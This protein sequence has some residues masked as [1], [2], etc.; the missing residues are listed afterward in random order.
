MM[1]PLKGTFNFMGINY[2]T[3]PDSPDLQKSNIINN[4]P[5]NIEFTGKLVL[6]FNYSFVCMT[7]DPSEALQQRHA[8]SLQSL[9]SP[10]ILYLFTYPVILFLI[11]IS[12]DSPRRRIKQ[13]KYE[14]RGISRI[15][16]HSLPI[17]PLTK[18]TVKENTASQRNHLLTQY[19]FSS[20][21]TIE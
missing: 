19:I 20:F 9:L 18:N 8:A 5:R 12:I 1:S 2:T 17:K 11:I 15:K 13:I 6:L 21:E 14:L 10:S 4:Y 16:I 3:H 7:V